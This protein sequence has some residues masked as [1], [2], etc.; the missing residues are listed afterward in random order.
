MEV[1]KGPSASS[2]VADVSSMDIFGE[3]GNIR[4][5]LAGIGMEI[6]KVSSLVFGLE[7]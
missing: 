2:T 7:R 6:W 1:M 3:D 5:I 4:I